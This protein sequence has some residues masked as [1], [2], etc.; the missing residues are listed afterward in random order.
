RTWKGNP[1]WFKLK[2]FWK[3]RDKFAGKDKATTT[4][5]E[6]VF[7]PE[8]ED[9]DDSVD[10][11]K[12]LSA[13]YEIPRAYAIQPFNL[14]LEVQGSVEEINRLAPK[15]KPV[16]LYQWS[17]DCQPFEEAIKMTRDLKLPN[18]NGG[19][20]RFDPEFLSYSWVMPLGRQV[21]QYQQIYASSSNEN[22]Y[23][24]LWRGKYYGFNLLPQTLKNT[25]TPLRI[26]PL[27][28]YYHMYSGEKLASLNAL[29]QNLEYIRSCKMIPITTSRFTEIV[30]GFYTTKVIP[31]KDRM[32]RFEDRGKLQ[33]IRFDR[34]TLCSVDFSRSEGVVGEH[35]FQGSLYVYLDESH[36]NSI[37]ALKE[38]S[39]VIEEAQEE[40]P[41]LIESRWRVWN[42]QRESFGSFRFLSQGYGKGEMRWKIPTDGN[43][44]VIWK[45]SENTQGSLIVNSQNC[46]LKFVIDQNAINPIEVTIQQKNEI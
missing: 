33:T 31:I 6:K 38:S 9:Y 17:G 12:Q 42:L 10:V 34:C 1:F 4:D 2:N 15:E 39:T 37:V 7:D 43:F 27:N 16:A 32:W 30:E 23:T 5:S 25:E 44:E 8:Q 3:K 28:V 35:H 29:K 26:K 46:E 21:G 13:G 11:L 20:T 19:D 40:V 45:D 14:V 22:T 36:P 24:N 41:Y 18:I